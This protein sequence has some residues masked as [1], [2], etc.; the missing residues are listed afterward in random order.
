MVSI[1]FIQRPG[2]EDIFK[3][4]ARD[5]P[6]GIA[7]VGGSL[8]EARL[9]EKI[10]SHLRNDGSKKDE[11]F[12]SSFLKGY[13]P[14]GSFSAKIDIGYLLRFY[15]HPIRKELDTIRH[16][17]NEFAHVRYPISFDN[18]RIKD[19][20]ANLK[21]VENYVRPMSEWKEGEDKPWVSY[22]DDDSFE[23]ELRDAKSRFL[24]SVGVYVSAFSKD[25]YWPEPVMGDDPP[26]NF[27]KFPS[28]DIS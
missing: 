28:P 22:I 18:Q 14:L 17:R 20:C 11:D 3:T 12:L 4:I 9:E 16:I 5:S 6:R 21:L 25:G 27:G 7:I 10:L 24:S 13:G 2:E 19:W 23:D 8:V 1:P 26:P 15:G